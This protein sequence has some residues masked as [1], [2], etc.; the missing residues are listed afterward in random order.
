MSL[1]DLLQQEDEDHEAW[2]RMLTIYQPLIKKWLARFG[3]PANDVDDLSQNIL[4]VVVRKLPDFEHAGREGAFRSWV[5]NITRNSLLEFW[6]A[7]KI[8]PVATGRTSFQESLNQLES[9]TSELSQQWNREYDQQVLASLL[10][11]IESEF[12]PS[13]W[14]AFTRVAL[15]GAKPADV[16]TELEVSVNSVFIAKSRVMSRLK[17]VGKYMID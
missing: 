11:Q 14:R 3:A 9:E 16:A 2:K 5:R 12:R 1:L 4:T 10:R 15:D 8:Q 6:R 13:T 7:K 17:A